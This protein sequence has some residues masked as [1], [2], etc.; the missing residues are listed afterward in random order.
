MQAAVALN[1]G[2]GLIAVHGF[3]R[4]PELVEPWRALAWT[5]GSLAATAALLAAIL[6]STWAGTGK[7]R[8]S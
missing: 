8:V 1:F 7:A 6:A 2:V 3:F 5:A 4:L